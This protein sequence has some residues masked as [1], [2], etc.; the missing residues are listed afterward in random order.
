MY[1]KFEENR[2]NLIKEKDKEY[3]NLQE[4]KED[5]Q[6]ADVYCTGSDQILEK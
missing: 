4:L 3:A 2:K 5:V 6:K 1:K